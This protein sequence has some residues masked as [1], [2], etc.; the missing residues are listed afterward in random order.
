MNASAQVQRKRPRTRPIDRAT[1][2]NA[3]RAISEG[4]K[5]LGEISAMVKVEGSGS[6]FDSGDLERD[7]PDIHIPDKA[8]PLSRQVIFGVHF[9]SALLV[10]CSAGLLAGVPLG[11]A[12]KG[13]ALHAAIVYLMPFLG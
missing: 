8:L 3:H 5:S 6:R 10:S 7:L 11:I 4:N 12:L 1:V 9:S 2:D 13:T